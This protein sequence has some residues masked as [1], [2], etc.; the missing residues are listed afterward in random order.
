MLFAS[1]GYEA[2]M[3][4][5][6]SCSGTVYLTNLGMQGKQSEMND[7]HPSYYPSTRMGHTL[8]AM[9]IGQACKILFVTT[10]VCPK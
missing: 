1:S 8:K 10:G 5:F 2:Q 3:M 7:S 4:L 9:S 6:T